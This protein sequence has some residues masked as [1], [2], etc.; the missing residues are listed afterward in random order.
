MSVA[1]RSTSASVRASSGDV[2]WDCASVN[3]A[4][5]SCAAAIGV[6]SVRL[7]GLGV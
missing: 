3:D 1:C 5:S 4:Y 2:Y 6:A 7:L